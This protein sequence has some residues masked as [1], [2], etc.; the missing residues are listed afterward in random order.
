[1]K[2]AL[3]SW[4]LNCCEAQNRPPNCQTRP[5]NSGLFFQFGST[6]I[7]PQMLQ[8][9]HRFSVRQ[10]WK[11]F[12]FFALFCFELVFGVNIK[13]LDNWISFPID[14]VWYQNDFIFWVMIKTLQVG[15]GEILSKLN[16][17]ISKSTQNLWFVSKL[18]N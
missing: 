11:T 18:Q 5:P 12:T 13:V 10:I 16:M 17:I 14:L 1:M 3:L 15:L 8:F 4:F 9:G 7:G 6:K 2:N